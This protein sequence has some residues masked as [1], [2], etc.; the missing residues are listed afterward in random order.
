M[1]AKKQVYYL[2]Q[3]Q[4]YDDV[5]EYYKMIRDEYVSYVQSKCD[6]MT[7]VKSSYVRRFK[8]RVDAMAEMLGILADADLPVNIDKYRKKKTEVE[9]NEK[10]ENTDGQA[11]EKT[12]DEVAV[13]VPG[14]VRGRA[15][16]GGTDNEQTPA[17][18]KKS[19]AKK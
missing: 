10:K 9:E 1:A 8:A 19:R 15:G 13:R 11:T 12:V 16:T 17:V 6:D 5:F 3:M 14:K 7:E 18:S 2:G 4:D